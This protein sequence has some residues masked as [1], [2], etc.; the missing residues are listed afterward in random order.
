MEVVEKELWIFFLV[1][2]W[3]GGFQKGVN[4]YKEN[5]WI[6]ILEHSF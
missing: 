4:E 5:A 2:Q 3:H 6:G 1:L